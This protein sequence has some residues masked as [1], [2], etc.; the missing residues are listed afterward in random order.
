M[1]NF[2]PGDSEVV[3]SKGSHLEVRHHPWQPSTTGLDVGRKSTNIPSLE[4]GRKKCVLSKTI[5]SISWSGESR[6][7]IKKRKKHL[8]LKGGR[9]A[10]PIPGGLQALRSLRRDRRRPVEKNSL[11]V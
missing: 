6:D 1:S 10:L 9:E 5:V 7:C 8:T 4:G 3:R 2:V 11:R